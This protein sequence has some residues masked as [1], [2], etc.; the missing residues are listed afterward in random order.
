MTRTSI[1]ELNRLLAD[2]PYEA[3]RPLDRGAMAEV[4]VVRHK[5]VHRKFALKLIHEQLSV[6]PG[7]A[8][9]LRLEARSLGGLDSK[10]IVAIID[11]AEAKNGALY[12][13]LELMTGHSL[14]KELRQKSPLPVPDAIRW[15]VHALK[16]LV[17]AHALGVIHRDIAPG[18]LFLK[19]VPG[20]PRTLKILDFGLARVIPTSLADGLIDLEGIHT[21]TG[22]I[23]GAPGYLSPEALSGRKVDHRS[24]LYSLSVV[25]YEMLTGKS[26]FELPGE[27]FPPIGHFRP[28]VPHDLDAIVAKNLARDPSQ[29]HQGALA[30]LTALSPF[31]EESSE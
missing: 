30:Y 4:F 31:F 18:N 25:F 14:K 21:S 5:V 20:Y 3:L 11:L 17:A 24:D 22:V 13:V 12:L 6:V 8:E 7:Y 15:T 1:E 27:D 26:P 2:S 10:H 16:G 29:R 28:E 9:R 19:E 23:V